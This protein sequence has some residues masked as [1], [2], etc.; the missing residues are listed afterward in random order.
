MY[1][2]VGIFVAYRVDTTHCLNAGGDDDDGGGHGP[3]DMAFT[4]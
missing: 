1:S 4:I 3:L 2:K